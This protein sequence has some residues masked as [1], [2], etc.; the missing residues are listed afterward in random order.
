MNIQQFFNDVLYKIYNK[1]SLVEVIFKNFL[2]M[3]YMY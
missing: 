2:L 1:W 3:K